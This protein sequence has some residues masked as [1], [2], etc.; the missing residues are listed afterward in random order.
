LIDDNRVL[1][2]VEVNKNEKEDQKLS[3]QSESHHIATSL[4]I[5]LENQK[6]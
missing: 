1:A 6:E 3:K 2:D 5:P 4:A